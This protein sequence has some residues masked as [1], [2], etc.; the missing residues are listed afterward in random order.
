MT[1]KLAKK[2]SVI[3]NEL[4]SQISDMAGKYIEA[5]IEFK[6][7]MS[8]SEENYKVTNGQVIWSA[9]KDKLIDDLSKNLMKFLHLSEELG[10]E[11]TRF[12]GALKAGNKQR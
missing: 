4:Q 9:G 10:Q 11:K 8:L 5:I 6:I 12:F 7:Q 2:G 3:T 1:E